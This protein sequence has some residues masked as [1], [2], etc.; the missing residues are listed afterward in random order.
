MKNKLTKS[1]PKK[2][3]VVQSVPTAPAY[4]EKKYRAEDSLRILMKAEEIRRD[5][6]LMKDVKELAKKQSTDLKKVC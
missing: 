6:T 3:A 2:N 5:K 4:D 1:A